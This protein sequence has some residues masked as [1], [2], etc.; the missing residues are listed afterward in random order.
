LPRQS[1]Q[2]EDAHA[3]PRPELNPL[4]NPVLGEHMG[5]WA[6][7]YFTSPPEKREEAVLELLRELEAANPR[8]VALTSEPLAASVP[9]PAVAAETLPLDNHATFLQCP[10]CG[11]DNPQSNQFCGMCGARMF[12]QNGSDSAFHAFHNDDRE[13]QYAGNG[14]MGPIDPYAS[15]R[16]DTRSMPSYGFE[17]SS[18]NPLDTNPNDLSLFRAVHK[19]DPSDLTWEHSTSHPYRAYVGAVLAV[20][21]MALAYMAWRGAQAT[22]PSSHAVTAAPPP[23]AT[24]TAAPRETAAPATT[25]AAPP[26]ADVGSPTS[27]AKNL[28]EGTSHP[29]VDVTAKNAA[30]PSGGSVER[31]NAVVAAPSPGN[32]TLSPIPAGAGRE[33]LA[34][35]QRYLNGSH[36]EPRNSAEAV[37]W[38]WKS[39][40]KQNSEATL[41]LA[42]LY[43]KGDGVSKNCDQARVLLDSAARQGMAGAGER[44]R[45][46][47]AF[48]CQ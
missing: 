26:K 33:E 10:S 9:G 23:A 35:A 20:V 21:I 39:I 7:V 47:Q 41:M 34:V 4:L 46:L 30:V 8:E 29:P 38:L 2:S 36:G 42:D 15:P 22:A 1:D 14:V 24:E 19:D 3:L 11:N 32:S 43:L 27:T 18:R 12:P 6:E 48:G 37:K 17:E 28:P 45:N 31:G 13:G 5:R 16:L 44:L 25:P 40:A